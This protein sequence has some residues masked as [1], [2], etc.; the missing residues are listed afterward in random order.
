MM[1]QLGVSLTIVI[2]MTLD[3]SF[4][5]LELSLML[6]EN[7]YSTSVT[8]DDHLYNGHIYIVQA[9]GVSFTVA[10]YAPRVINYA[11]I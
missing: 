7:T 1:S 3:V 9:I 2:L 11:P 4:M 5:L 10:N 8:H 6:Q